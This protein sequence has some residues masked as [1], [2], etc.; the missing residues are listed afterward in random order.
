MLI[1][2]NT[3]RYRNIVST[4]RNWYGL[5]FN[6]VYTD[7]YLHHGLFL[8]V[9]LDESNSTV[10]IHRCDSCTVPLSVHYYDVSDIPII[11]EDLKKSYC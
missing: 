1:D 6:K 9:Q 5:A 10:N 7:Y 4:L 3:H 11:L 2:V 8:H